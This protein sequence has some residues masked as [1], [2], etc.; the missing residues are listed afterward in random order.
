[1]NFSSPQLY[2]T[3]STRGHEPW[4]GGMPGQSHHPEVVIL[5][6]AHQPLDWHYQ[7]VLEQIVVYHAV[8]HSDTIVV[9]TRGKKWVSP[10]ELDVSNSIGV[11]SED[12][13]R[14]GGE[15]EVVPLHL[16]VKGAD[17]HVVPTRMDGD[18]GDPLGAALKL[19]R[20]LLLDQVVDSHVALRRDEE[21]RADRVEENTLNL[22]LGLG[23][24]HLAS[25]LGQLVD[26]H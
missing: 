11:I 5:G 12:L 4:L 8:R 3:V 2:V 23:E 13:V 9:A 22:T 15:V 18:G 21:V 14:Q 25:P 26:Q 10:V 19:P 17:Q 6:V 1:M 20:H 7:G 16:L 24:R